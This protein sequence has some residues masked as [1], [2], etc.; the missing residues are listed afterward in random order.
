LFQALTA[1]LN[2][3]PPERLDCIGRVVVKNYPL[4]ALSAALLHFPGLDE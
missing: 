1:R 3:Y 4:Y 2:V